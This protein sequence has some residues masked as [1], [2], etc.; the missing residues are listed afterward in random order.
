MSELVLW[1][2]VI[3]SFACSVVYVFAVASA[4]PLYTVSSFRSQLSPALFRHL[5]LFLLDI[6]FEFMLVYDCAASLSYMFLSCTFLA[7][8]QLQ[9]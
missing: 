9:H 7:T 2:A 8:H 5:A 3:P 1:F 6:Y 4:H